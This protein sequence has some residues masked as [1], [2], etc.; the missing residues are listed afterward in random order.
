[1][2][3]NWNLVTSVSGNIWLNTGN[4]APLYI[5]YRAFDPGASYADYISWV[6][7]YNHKRANAEVKNT[8]SLYKWFI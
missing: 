5:W 7:F 4:G 1:M 3:V 2:Y 6:A 8:Y